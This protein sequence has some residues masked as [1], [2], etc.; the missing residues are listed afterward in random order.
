MSG[1]ETG[2]AGARGLDLSGRLPGRVSS[3][4]GNGFIFLPQVRKRGDPLILNG[5]QIS[6]VPLCGGKLYAG[7]DISVTPGP[8]SILLNSITLMNLTV[9]S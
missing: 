8:R 2:E 6:Q 3:I 1:P 5:C 7:K 9:R 4:E